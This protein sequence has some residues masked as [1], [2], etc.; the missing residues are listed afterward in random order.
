MTE[1]ETYLKRTIVPFGTYKGKCLLELVTMERNRGVSWI[2]FIKNKSGIVFETED[3]CKM[4]TTYYNDIIMNYTKFPF[5]K[6]NG[7]FVSDVWK[8]NPSYIR[9]MYDKMSDDTVAN[10]FML[11]VF[12]IAMNM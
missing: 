3:L 11:E 1:L 7:E 9:Y 8:E 10:N 2:S 12:E 5:G 6:Y 4:V